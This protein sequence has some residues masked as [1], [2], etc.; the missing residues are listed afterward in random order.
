[1]QLSQLTTVCFSP[2]GATRRVLAAVAEGIQAPGSLLLDLTTTATSLALTRPSE[3]SLALIGAPVYRGRVPQTARE[4]LESLQA[5]DMPAVLVVTYG[6]RAFDDA[7]LELAD[8]AQELGFYPFA[9]AAFIGEHSF[10]TEQTPIAPGRPD[11]RDLELARDFGRR[12]RAIHAGAA[13]PQELPAPDMPGNRP[14]RETPEPPPLAPATDEALCQLC[15]DCAKVCPVD[16]IE[17]ADATVRTDPGRCIWCCACVKACP[18]QARS[19]D[20][21]AVEKVRSW[22][23]ENFTP[24]K[25]PE[26]FGI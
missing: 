1:M 16:A 17:L 24:R 21:P 3:Q 2:T 8:L 10:S 23:Y 12:V 9:G 7:L 20:A 15:G 26:F 5:H 4:R 25:E 14:Y 19:M 6:N 22:L 18:T 13:R 11:H